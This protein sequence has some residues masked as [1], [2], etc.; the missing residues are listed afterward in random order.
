MRILSLGTLFFLL[1]SSLRIGMPFTSRVSEDGRF[2]SKQEKRNLIYPTNFNRL[3]ARDLFTGDLSLFYSPGNVVTSSPGQAKAEQIILRKKEIKKD[4]LTGRNSGN[5]AT[6]QG[7][8]EGRML[9]LPYFLSLFPPLTRERE[10]PAREKK[11]MENA[12]R[13]RER[14]YPCECVRASE[15]R[16]RVQSSFLS[17]RTYEHSLSLQLTHTHA[18]AH[19]TW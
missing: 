11:K 5:K 7:R 12:A 1:S 3:N 17:S 19:S 16:Q 15:K 18:R 2:C 6:K 8:E 14:E 4:L 13:E 9:C 10:K